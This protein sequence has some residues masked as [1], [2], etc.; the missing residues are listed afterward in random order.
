MLQAPAETALDKFVA[1]ST[2]VQIQKVN[3]GPIQETTLVGYIAVAASAAGG[4]GVD[5][6]RLATE[7]HLPY[8]VA[9]A[10]ANSE[11]LP[12]SAFASLPVMHSNV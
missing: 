3:A 4:E 9:A 12:K 10:V 2:L 7:G 8:E 6:K 5:W 11:Q 1:G